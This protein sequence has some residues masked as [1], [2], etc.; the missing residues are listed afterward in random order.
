MDYYKGSLLDEKKNKELLKLALTNAVKYKGKANPGTVIS[1]SLGLYPELKEDMKSLAISANNIV[2]NI[3]SLD[4]QA[5][6]EL[7]LELDP[8]ALKKEEH[9]L[10]GFLKIKKGEKVITAFPPGPE[11]YPHIGHAKALLINYELA[12]KYEGEFILRFED[13]NPGL[14]KAEFYEIMQE[15]FKWLGVSW[16]KLVYA[17]DYMDLYYKHAEELIKKGEAYVC[18]SKPEE[19]KE[20][21]EKGIEPPA[22]KN[23]V[24]K[25][26]ELWNNLA[27]LNPGEA[28]VRLKIDIS[29]KNSTMRD[30]TIF[31]ILNE[32]HARHGNKYKVWPNYDFQ[33]SIMDG[34]FNITHRLRSKEFEL[35][36]ELQRYIQRLLG[37]KE[38]SIYEFAR[39]NLKGVESSGRVIREKILSNE[40][41]GWDDPSLTTLVALKKRGFQPEAIKSFVLSTGI[42][43]NE[44]TLTWDDFI[45][46]NKRL[47]DKEA[48]RFFF[49]RDPI[50]IKIVGAPKKTIKLHSHPDEKDGKREFNVHE[51]YY[52]SKQDFDSLKPGVYRLI[53]CLNFEFDGESFKYLDN[54]I[55]TYKNKGKGMFHFV[56]DDVKG[57][58]LMP[59]KELIK[60]FVEPGALS[61]AKGKVIQFERFGFVCKNDNFWFTHK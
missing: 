37:Y 21:R 43:K 6:E 54:E 34:Y 44:S 1:G 12:K 56:I 7:L 29:H 8:D 10:F 25:N 35:R 45:L 40:L 41:I 58:V 53:E 19:F 28:V 31:R 11:K 15:D 17:S 57:E 61:V 48:K 49:V 20:F 59:T 60:G 14:V 47:L 38:T 13:T 27:N 52:I 33:N 50:K 36:N 23:S 4:I 2:K 26:L 39:F 22:Y 3:N 9:D 51:D 5:Q 32:E 42:T 16:D 18:F 55:S 46:H 30:P 24:E